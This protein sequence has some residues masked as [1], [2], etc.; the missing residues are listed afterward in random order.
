LLVVNPF[1]ASLC[2]YVLQKG[3][4]QD[5]GCSRLP[6]LEPGAVPAD[7]DE[8]GR[9]EILD[10]AAHGGSLLAAGYLEGF[11]LDLL[12]LTGTTLQPILS[13]EGE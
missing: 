10:P 3:A 9:A 5:R 1:W 6:A 4:L 2:S 7:L 11:G 8:D 13:T 12:V